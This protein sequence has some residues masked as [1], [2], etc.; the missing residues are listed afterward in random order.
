M[1]KYVL[2]FLAILS[3]FNMNAYG[4]DI[5]SRNN[6]KWPAN[7]TLI[8]GSLYQGGPTLIF[9]LNGKQIA[10]LNDITKKTIYSQ[11]VE[12]LFGIIKVSSNGI[13]TYFDSKNDFKQIGQE[14]VSGTLFSEGFAIV[15]A[16]NEGLKIIN[17][18]GEAMA[19]LNDYNGKTI[20]EA[21][22][23]KNGL[24][25]FKNSK[26]LW[27]FI[28][29][30]GK[31]VIEPMYSKVSNFNE[32][33]CVVEQLNL[34]KV[35]VGIIDKKGSFVFNLTNNMLLANEVVNG[36]IAFRKNYRGC[37]IMAVNGK[38]IFEP[39][40]IY[41]WV[42]PYTN[43]NFTPF[44]TGEKYGLLNNKGEIMVRAKFDIIV[45][46]GNQFIGA[47]L[48]E[49]N[50]TNIYNLKGD[51]VKKIPYLFILPLP[52]GNYLAM[53]REG[54]IFLDKNLKEL[55]KSAIFDN[56]KFKVINEEPQ[57]AKT[58]YF[59]TKELVSRIANKIG[60]NSINGL[61]TNDGVKQMIDKFELKKDRSYSGE[62]Y[63]YGEN[64]LAQLEMYAEL[65]NNNRNLFGRIDNKY[66][67]DNLSAEELEVS[68]MADSIEAAVRAADSLA[69]LES[70]MMADGEP[71]NND[72]E[73]MY[74]DSLSYLSDTKTQEVTFSE[75]F[76]LASCVI[77]LRFNDN[78]KLNYFE[79]KTNTCNTCKL[80]GTNINPN[81]KIVGYNL[82]ISLF[83]KAQGKTEEFINN[84]IEDLKTKGYTFEKNNNEYIIFNT[85]LQ[86]KKCGYLSL[87]IM[88]S[89]EMNLNITF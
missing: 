80:K 70:I 71:D 61:N 69:A 48:R 57:P 84:L 43:A 26:N 62:N 24:A 56:K 7:K 44:I 21:Y 30:T 41:D 76:D 38:V 59:D 88:G 64:E 3:I 16:K 63:V 36:K 27:G 5:F 83:G 2:S 89:S 68:Q 74:F 31:V 23:F 54:T 58:N 45:L 55:S 35:A 77:N 53:E 34:G 11:N 9:D 79:E 1:K 51:L 49:S 46:M 28:D 22:E 40:P 15:A 19:L 67:Q 39:N 65:S 47:N 32:N 10:N 42:L 29:Q 37:G 81:A 4:R 8:M 17:T 20:E 82:R 66:L 33:Y 85:K 60:T 50:E 12:E 6:I 86:N 73:K 72:G 52:N 14:Y 87:P 25:A 13:I 18:K 78:I 75:H